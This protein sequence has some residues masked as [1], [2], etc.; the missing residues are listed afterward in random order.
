M[1]KASLFARLKTAI[2]RLRPMSPEQRFELA[3]DAMLTEFRRRVRKRDK[4]MRESRSRLVR[5]SQF[6]NSGTQFA[7][8]LGVY[9][10]LIKRIGEDYIECLKTILLPS[11]GIISRDQKNQLC[12]EFQKVVVAQAGAAEEAERRFAVSVGRPNEVHSVF[13]PLRGIFYSENT[14]IREHIESIVKQANLILSTKQRAERRK[15]LIRTIT[16]TIVAIAKKIFS[17]I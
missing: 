15:S 5:S 17:G 12:T 16:R 6:E 4:E 10:P 14:R 2:R 9:G 7:D 13:P 1:A 8:R 11:C 3:L